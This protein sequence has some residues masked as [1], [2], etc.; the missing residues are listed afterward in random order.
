MSLMAE[1]INLLY[2]EAGDLPGGEGGEATGPRILPLHIIYFFFV[3]L[4][5]QKL[6]FLLIFTN[7]Q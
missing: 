7:V 3:N 1:S 2:P 6:L 4:R 5:V